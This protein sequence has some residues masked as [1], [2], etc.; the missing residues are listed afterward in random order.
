MNVALLQ[1]QEFWA[2]K[3]PNLSICNLELFR[4]SSSVKLDQSTAQELA[5][6]LT[7]EGYLQGRSDWGLDLDEMARSI[8]VLSEAG[9]P[10]V[11]AFLFDEFWI[12]FRKL[13]NLYRAVLGEDYVFL[14]DFWV[15]NVD[16]SKGE[17]GW[18]PHRDR[19]RIALFADG[20]PKSVTTWIP[21]TEAT[22]LNGCIYVVP[23]SEDP[24]YGTEE[25]AAWR[26]SLN[27]VRALPVSPGDFLIWNQ[28]LLHWGGKT[29]KRA[30]SSRISLSFEVQRGDVPPFNEPL[31]RPSSIVSF[32]G[33]LR[34]VAKQLLQ[35]RH[36][37]QLSDEMTGFALS[38][39]H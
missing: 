29:S 7:E 14:P 15:W 34:L 17:A 39:T 10:P 35:Y 9:I 33:R 31:L 20:S 8:R 12:A 18:S 38:L 36:M 3:F 32:G 2:D 30:R 4:Q 5:G 16:P 25:E 37:Y 1:S 23:V 11:F 28:S 21:L 27:G 6:Q 22:P 24:T 13:D 26:P 19:G